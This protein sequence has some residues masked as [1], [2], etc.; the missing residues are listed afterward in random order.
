MLL[1]NLAFLTEIDRL[2]AVDRQSELI[3]QSR[4]ENSAEHSWHLAMC[5][6]V[7]GPDMDLDVLKVIKMLL[8]HDIVEI[9]AGDMPLHS[10][11]VSPSSKQISENEAAK[12]IFGLLPR[13]RAVELFESWFEFE[14]G[15]SE[16]ARFARGVDRLQPLIQNIMNGGGTWNHNGVDETTVVS[17]YGPAI[18]GA[19]AMLWHEVRALVREH[20]KKRAT[21]D[22]E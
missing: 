13:H 10:S 19:S 17:R 20:F 8:V 1:E 4:R 9:D 2:K 5:A 21:D 16:E 22:K 14:Y 7:L 11:N 3:G 18:A 6:L 15:V 12:R